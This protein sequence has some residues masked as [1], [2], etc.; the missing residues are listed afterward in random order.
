M[1]KD[2][3][4]GFLGLTMKAGRVLY[5]AENVD[6]TRTELLLLAADAGG[7]AR[8]NAAHLADKRK[9]VLIETSFSKEELGQAIGKKPCALLAVTGGGFDKRLTEIWDTVSRG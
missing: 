8:R 7:S 2:S 3:F 5:G 1:A 9:I 4:L 6:T